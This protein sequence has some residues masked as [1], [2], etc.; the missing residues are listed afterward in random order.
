MRATIDRVTSKSV[1]VSLGPCGA[2][3]LISDIHELAK[4]V[5]VF[6]LVDPPDRVTDF[7]GYAVGG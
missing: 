7:D 6:Q 2:A 3:D 1:T 5:C 4:T